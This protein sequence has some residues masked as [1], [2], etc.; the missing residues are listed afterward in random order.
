MNIF[1][2]TNRNP[3]TGEVEIDKSSISVDL[4]TYDSV[5]AII[6]DQV[7]NNRPWHHHMGVDGYGRD[8]SIRHLLHISYD[9]MKRFRM[10]KEFSEVVEGWIA[11]NPEGR[12]TYRDKLIAEVQKSVTRDL[13]ED[14]KVKR[15][16]A[17]R[18]LTVNLNVPDG[19]RVD[20][21]AIISDSDIDKENRKVLVIIEYPIIEHVPIERSRS[22]EKAEKQAEELRKR[23]RELEE[24]EELEEKERDLRKRLGF[25]EKNP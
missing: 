1:T 11:E 6:E 7:N 9:T 19:Y 20:G 5:K 25:N 23:V 24:L 14:Q 12:E 4:H 10:S 22:N 16:R 8:I 17:A 13:P 21:E 3:K 18:T 2:F 15:N